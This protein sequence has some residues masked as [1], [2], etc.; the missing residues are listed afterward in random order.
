MDADPDNTER[1]TQLQGLLNSL[2]IALAPLLALKY[3]TN[4]DALYPKRSAKGLG[5][6]GR[7]GSKPSSLR[8]GPTIHHLESEHMI[9]FAVGAQF[10]QLVGLRPLDRGGAIG[11]EVDRAQTTIMIY[12][13]AADRKTAVDQAI[14]SRF[15]NALERAEVGKRIS[16]ARTWTSAGG[17]R[18]FESGGQAILADVIDAVLAVKQDS[19]N[20]TVEAIRDENQSRTEDQ[21]L[22]N[23]QRRALPGATEPS[24]PGSDLVAAAAG[25]Q[26]E[27]IIG[28]ITQSV[29][30]RNAREQREVAR[31]QLF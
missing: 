14:I 3:G 5:V 25:Q 30:R 7:H 4:D 28:L 17:G 9:P 1:S 12:K 27:D 21:Q 31:R 8:N 24:L 23:G 20:R 6:I 29:E 2:S 11:G 19:T 10:W 13:G 16:A 22:T 26:Y 18:D 15:K